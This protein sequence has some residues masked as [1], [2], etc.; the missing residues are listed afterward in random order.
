MLQFVYSNGLSI[1][2]KARMGV[3]TDLGTTIGFRAKLFNKIIPKGGIG[4]ELGVY[5][6]T[7][8]TFILST[9]QPH[10]LHLECCTE[11]NVLK[12]SE[13]EH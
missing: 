3:I 8:S 13:F 6:G 1:L 11:I 5:K 4:V 12:F 10:R 9:N 2:A 7:L